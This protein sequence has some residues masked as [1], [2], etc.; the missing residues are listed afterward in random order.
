MKWH[1]IL[2]LA[3]L[4]GTLWAEEWR[5]DTFAVWPLRPESAKSSSVIS[6]SD[7]LV[8]GNAHY[9]EPGIR[10]IVNQMAASGIRNVWF[11]LFGGGHAQ[12]PTRVPEATVANYA[13]QGGDF[14]QFDG[15]AATENFARKLGLGFCVWFTPL[16]E[17]HAWPDNVRSR[18]VDIHP[19]LGDRL[20]N[21]LAAGAPSLAFEAYRRYKCAFVEE[22]FS[23]YHPDALVIDLERC[24]APV[25]NNQWGYLPDEVAKFNLE[26]KRTG[27]PAPD[28]P[29]WLRFRARHTTELVEA[30]RKIVKAHNPRA[31]LIVMYP[32]NRPLTAHWDI[33]EIAKRKLADG[34]VL[35]EHGSGWGSPVPADKSVWRKTATETGLPVRPILYTLSNGRAAGVEAAAL[36]RDG[37]PG[38]V[39]FE[40]TYLNF[41]SL[42]DLPLAVNAP[43][44]ARIESPVYDFSGGGEVMVLGAGDWTLAAAGKTLGEGNAF[45]V[46]QV[47]IPA[48]F[49]GKLELEVKLP[50]RSQSCGIALQGYA[51]D[52]AG[53][54]QP[55]RSDGAWPGVATVAQPGIPPFLNSEVT[56]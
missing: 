19:E 40:T 45:A 54:R 39:W 2:A 18:Y 26:F 5:S 36:L 12:Y 34:L 10:A 14:S 46:R 41:N 44:A 11:R 4:A 24:G 1:G 23:R 31:E 21:G 49:K 15:L 53:R 28:D 25:R 42:Y 6:F 29:D 43:M 30:M 48:G 38:I 33:A 16:E 51:V 8:F 27:N 56:K 47:P 3:L 17:A 13:G 7:W 52:A 37:A 35:A 32:A 55:I 20:A 50:A 9:G 22:V